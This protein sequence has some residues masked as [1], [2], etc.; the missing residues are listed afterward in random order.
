MEMRQTRWVGFS[1][2]QWGMSW[3]NTLDSEGMESDEYERQIPKA[4]LQTD[5]SPFGELLYV[6]LQLRSNVVGHHPAQPD[7]R[8]QEHTSHTMPIMTFRSTLPSP[9]QLNNPNPIP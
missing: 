2:C 7:I 5:S 4:A 9:N 8:I 6:G 1:L 3:T